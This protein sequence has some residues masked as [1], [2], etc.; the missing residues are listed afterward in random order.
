VSILTSTYPIPENYN[1][2][3]IR[4]VLARQKRGETAELVTVDK[5]PVYADDPLR[6]SHILLNNYFIAAGDGAYDAKP[7]SL[8][9]GKVILETPVETWPRHL[10]AAL[11]R[12]LFYWTH[13][14][15]RT[16]TK[17]G[18]YVMWRYGSNSLAASLRSIVAA[19]LQR[20]P[21]MNE[22]DLVELIEARMIGGQVGSD[23]GENFGF[24]LII[25]A[26][27]AFKTR[28]QGLSPD[29]RAAITKLHEWRQKNMYGG[30]DRK[31]KA[32]TERIDELLGQA[33]PERKQVVEAGEPWADAVLEALRDASAG[34]KW[35]PLLRHGAE[36]SS[37]K[38]SGKWIKDAKK[39]IDAIG[40]AEFVRCADEWLSLATKPR[41][42]RLR[43]EQLVKLWY[44]D[45]DVF[46][47]K[48]E[49]VLKGLA[50]ACA[51]AAD[52]RL[53]GPLGALAESCY[54]KIPNVGPR[55]PKVGNAC[56]IALTML[57]GQEPRAELSRLKAK[58]KQ[59]TARK[60]IEKALGVSAAAAGMTTDDLEELAVPTYGLTEIGRCEQQIG[61]FTAELKIEAGDVALNFIDAKGKSRASVPAELKKDFAQ[62]LKGLQQRFK[63]LTKMLPAQRDRLERM[64]MNRRELPY[65]AWRERYLDHPV[66]GTLAR[67]L[68]WNFGDDAVGA[69]RN[70]K[71]VDVNDKPLKPDDKTM[72]RLWHPIHADADS[73]LAWRNWLERHQ[74]TQPFKQAHREVYLL[75][76]AERETR[77]YSN[78]FAAHILRQHILAALCTQRGWRYRL[79]GTW[80]GGGDTMPTIELPKWNLRV[81]YWIDG[82]DFA[83]VT[84]HGALQYVGTDQV[85]F[86]RPADDRPLP[87]VDVPPLAFSEMMRDVDLFV[88]V[89]SAG[90]DPNWQD[91]GNR[92]GDYW[93]HYSF[94]D[95][96]ISAQTR[97]EVLE[98][99]LPRLKIASRCSIAKNFLLVKGD[100]RTYKIH[101]GSANILMEPND[102][103]L[104]IVAERG[105]H[106]PKAEL[107]LPFEGDQTLSLILSKAFLL[108]NDKDI[109]DPS[110]TRQIGGK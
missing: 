93:Q 81:A 79:I 6:E 38:P 26:C 74:V 83:D 60:M 29:L 89:A 78:R 73:V 82:G 47:I 1:P 36:G 102:Q 53:A 105:G 71:I 42:V 46:S 106:S 94:G 48:N 32:L 9:A 24:N 63:D 95:L 66:V 69:W 70:G 51:A 90:N 50:W 54:K 68:I 65:A 100:L 28:H 97:R 77:T 52:A 107:F 86:F 56:L 39:L 21:P 57:P 75:T 80:D 91:G 33:P 84:D 44:A 96:G 2:P 23:V 108:V 109:T 14:V 101:L 40:A 30:G 61:S 99:L 43:D 64:P 37:S 67:R 22:K 45:Y 25:K 76:D 58:V 92:F 15:E 103:Y 5:F 85:R 62:P 34:S 10:A 16:D 7:A 8:P 12:V 19:M 87:L 13:G 98:R 59:P 110:I 27:E 88:G 104:C 20:D 11:A 41:T 35:E 3:P 72:V 17:I 31:D 4:D 55:S 49:D 18:S